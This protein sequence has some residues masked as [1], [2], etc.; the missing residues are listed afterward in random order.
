MIEFQENIENTR[1]NIWSLIIINLL[2]FILV[3]I[4]KFMLR[5]KLE[6][7]LLGVL[8]CFGYSNKVIQSTYN[9]GNLLI[10]IVGF[11]FG[12]LPFGVLLGLMSGYSLPII[13]G[14]YSSIEIL[15]GI[16]FLFMLTICS[17]TTTTIFINM[18]TEKENIYE[19]IKYES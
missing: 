5:L 6:L 7:H 8:K 14:I 18:Y 13:L 11:I 19:L 12:Y 4:I 2:A 10:I 16:Y 17:V 15:Y 3:L 9:I 1:K